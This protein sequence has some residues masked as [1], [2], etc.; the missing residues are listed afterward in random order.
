MNMR[1]ILHILLFSLI[2]MTCEAGQYSVGE[3][4]NV[5]KQDHTKHLVNPDG[6]V[7]ASTQAQI[8]SLLLDIRRQSSAEVVAVIVDDIDSD[9]IDSYATELF[10]GWGIGKG[11]KNNGV[12]ILV[13]KD[14]RRGVIRTGY[15]AEGVLPDIISGR[16]LHNVMFP[17]FK[18]GDYEGGM[19]AGVEAVHKVITD[20]D[21]AA[22]LMSD[23]RDNYDIFTGTDFL[24]IYLWV[25]VIVALSLL[26][27]VGIM[28]QR[29]NSDKKM[30][31]YEKYEATSK[32]MLPLLV[33]SL[34]LIGIPI[35][36][37]VVLWLVR[38]HWRDHRRRCQRCNTWMQKLDEDTDNK[39][40]TYAQDL[41]EKLKSVDY[42]VWLC[43][44]CGEKDV[45]SFVN[46]ASSYKECPVCH[47]RTMKLAGVRILREPTV[48]QEGIGEKQYMCLNCNHTHSDRYTIAR[49]EP[50]VVLVAPGGGGRGG[51]GFSG[52][53][54][55][56]GGFGGGLTGGGGA[57]G[58]W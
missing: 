42:D 7:S 50:P 10:N 55:F 14:M 2:A 46:R 49:K 27:F 24:K 36:A 18:E 54:S 19:L 21:A 57:S 51:G 23:E 4:P 33:I 44:H 41:E 8:D 3:L 30:T 40:L 39:Y 20:P 5:Q 9:D 26:L 28:I 52:G 47:A 31:D 12:L 43:P 29:K 25:A 16:V 38:R 37:W 35:L 56:G 48:R 34:F 17:R 11:D 32:Y 53:G 15:G 45:Y 58:G 22:E 13:A 1:K 6:I